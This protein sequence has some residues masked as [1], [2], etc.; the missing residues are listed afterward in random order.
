MIQSLGKVTVTTPGTPVRVTINTGNPTQNRTCHA[1][2]VEQ[3]PGNTGKIWVGTAQMDVSTGEGV[4]AVLAIP[5]TN[6]IPT[7]SVANTIVLG[8]LIPNQIWLDADV[9]GEWAIV[10]IVVT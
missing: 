9:G 5:T 1:L 7:F 10:T 8:G 3:W 6:F 2:M 4:Y